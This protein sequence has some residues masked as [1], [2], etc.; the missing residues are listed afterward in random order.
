M[1]WLRSFPNQSVSVPE[2][3]LSGVHVSSVTTAIDAS[4][5]VVDN[6]LE[7]LTDLKASLVSL[8]TDE[9][10]A[11]LSA[12]K[13]DCEPTAA[14]EPTIPYADVN[15]ISKDEIIFWTETLCG[16]STTMFV[17]SNVGSLSIDPKPSIQTWNVSAANDTSQVDGFATFQSTWIDQV[18]TS[19]T[20]TIHE[21]TDNYGRRFFT[22]DNG[23][24]NSF[25]AIVFEV[26][27]KKMLTLGDVILPLN[28]F[29]N[30][31]SCEFKSDLPIMNCVD[32]QT[33]NEEGKILECVECVFPERSL[34]IS[35]MTTTKVMMIMTH[36]SKVYTSPVVHQ[37]L[38]KN[39]IVY[40]A[41]QTEK[42][43]YYG[44][45]VI[46]FLSGLVYGAALISGKYDSK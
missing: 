23:I 25:I 29:F 15:N 6:R 18:V 2:N 43:W 46:V 5:A 32:R 28:E 36:L 35:K 3:D 19:H 16:A 12:R 9:E 27:G 21:R 39:E 1:N 31:N 24:N 40:F 33:G 7:L 44:S 41:Q 17:S 11:L 45:L 20:P 8:S 30:L 38:K 22:F 42:V 4:S 26:Q 14:N 37:S 13:G 34:T 10:A